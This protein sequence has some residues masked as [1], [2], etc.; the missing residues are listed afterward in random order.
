MDSHLELFQK[1]DEFSIPNF[2]LGLVGVLLIFTVFLSLFYY[3]DVLGVEDSTAGYLCEPL[4]VRL[5]DVD[6]TSFRVQW[7][8]S[9][10]CLGLVKYGT[11]I[12][13]INFMALDEGG[14]KSKQNHSVKIDD[15]Q[16]GKTYY[17]VIHSDG[18]DYGSQGSPMVVS[19]D[20][21]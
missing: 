8:T 9:A 13:T 19:T 20:S 4:D 17:L 2:I 15:L 11:S 18:K 1:R 7:S 21:F 16:P 6:T 14:H 10:E 3:R 12:D 5:T